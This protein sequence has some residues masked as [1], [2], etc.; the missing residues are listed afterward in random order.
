MDTQERELLLKA[1]GLF[2][3]LADI[4]LETHRTVRAL[5][6][7]VQTQIPGLEAEYRK[8]HTE[9]LFATS[10]SVKINKMI[11]EIEDTIARLK[12]LAPS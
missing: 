9:A 6:Q 5:A 10:E 1:C 4:Q 2:R 7:A 8:A 12:T 3:E 11:L